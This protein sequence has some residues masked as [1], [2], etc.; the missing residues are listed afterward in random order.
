DPPQLGPVRIRLTADADGIHGQVVVSNDAIRR[1]IE[2]QLPELRQR[3]EA[4][5]VSVQNLDV[6]AGDTGRSAAD[7]GTP[8]YGTDFAPASTRPGTPTT[9]ARAAARSSGLL[10]VMA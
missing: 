6:S 9:Q 4:A 5:G 8:T 1:M 3:L 7:T 2:S 10:D